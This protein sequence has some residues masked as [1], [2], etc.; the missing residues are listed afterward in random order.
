MQ[1]NLRRSPRGCLDLPHWQEEEEEE[2]EEE[3][4]AE[5]TPAER[6][7]APNGYP[8]MGISQRESVRLRFGQRSP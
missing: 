1:K 4:E 6:Q 2:S 5:E 7:Q 8:R 3:E